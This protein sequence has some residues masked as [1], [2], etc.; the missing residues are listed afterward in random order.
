MNRVFPSKILLFGEYIVRQGSGALA[1]P[2]SRFSGQWDIRP[3]QSNVILSRIA[4]FIK[5]IEIGEFLV[6]Y[7]YEKFN[8]DINN[9]L[10][11]NSN[12][13]IGYGVGSSGAL[14][15]AIYSEYFVHETKELSDMRLILSKIE[16]FFHKSSSG[17]DP[18]VSYLNKPIVVKGGVD[19]KI[20]TYPIGQMKDYCLYLVN[21]GKIRSTGKFVEIFLNKN[22]S[23]DFR[24]KYTEY[25]IELTNEIIESY[26][27]NNEDNVFKLFQK[28]SENQYQY[29]SEMILPELKTIWKKALDSSYVAMKLCGA[30]GGGYY[31]LMA[32]SGFE[33]SELLTEFETL[34]I[35]PNF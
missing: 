17:I 33:L 7:N 22:S 18:L 1:I 15:A 9:D 6:D 19:I 26:L 29:M 5:E 28:I 23:T 31:L 8:S 34:Q 27:S 35:N 25:Q 12:I 2:Y 24:N 21:S 14:V 16:D 4:E 10:V 20:I 30:G 32:K 13:P 3:E 11:F